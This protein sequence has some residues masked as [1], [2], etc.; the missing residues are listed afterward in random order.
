MA[1]PGNGFINEGRVLLNGVL[2]KLD[3]V[4]ESVQRQYERENFVYRR[5]VLPA[6]DATGTTQ[7]QI[8]PPPGTLWKIRRITVTGGANGQAAFYLN[9]VQ[10]QNLLDGSFSNA[11]L[12]AWAP[13]GDGLYIPSQNPLVVRFFNQPVNQ[14]CTVNLR[15]TQVSAD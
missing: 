11:A 13:G 3:E 5:M 9:D 7:D 1:G 4:I 14:I 6:A 2:D 15:I 10:P 12:D 8:V